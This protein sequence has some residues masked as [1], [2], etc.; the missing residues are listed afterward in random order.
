MLLLGPIFT[1]WALRVMSLSSSSF[2]GVAGCGSGDACG[3]V[4]VVAGGSDGV[5]KG[6]ACGGI[7]G[8]CCEWCCIIE[9]SGSGRAGFGSPVG[10]NNAGAVV[11]PLLSGDEEEEELGGENDVEEATGG[12]A[13]DVAVL[14]SGGGCPSV[15]PLGALLRAM[16][17]EDLLLRLPR[18]SRPALSCSSREDSRR[19]LPMMALSGLMPAAGV[20]R[21]W[22]ALR[23]GLESHFSIPSASTE[24]DDDEEDDEEE[25]DGYTGPGNSVRGVLLMAARVDWNDDSLGSGGGVGCEWGS[26]FGGGGEASSSTNSCLEGVEVDCDTVSKFAAEFGVLRVLTVA[27]EV[28]ADTEWEEEAAAAR[29]GVGG[30]F[31]KLPSGNGDDEESTA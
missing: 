25:E 26:S 16:S 14:D 9:E 3:G 19:L 5:C 1:R 12:A 11:L 30:V 29:D 18:R 23:R 22:R 6:C 24:S 10:R 13:N 17:T 27:A 2:G 7:A 31:L 20:S 8:G 28:L 15:T 21:G 4:T